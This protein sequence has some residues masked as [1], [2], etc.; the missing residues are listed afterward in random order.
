MYIDYHEPF[1]R[2][3]WFQHGIYRVYLHEIHP[4]S[5]SENSLFHP[6]PWKSAIRIIHGAYEMGIGHSETNETPKIDCK[7]IIG[8]DTAYEMVEK[9]AWHYVNPFNSPV[10]SLMVTGELNDREMTVEPDKKFRDLTEGETNFIVAMITEY[11]LKRKKA[12]G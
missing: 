4:S 1:V 5:A 8:K 2:R 7:L 11:Y 9:D 12:N 3:V 6:H 10:F